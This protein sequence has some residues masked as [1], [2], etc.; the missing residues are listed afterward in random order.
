MPRSFASDVNDFNFRYP[1]FFEEGDLASHNILNHTFHPINEA[2]YEST[3]LYAKATHP[4]DFI[5][6]VEKA[7]TEAEAVIQFQANHYTL[8]ANHEKCHQPI[9]GAVSL[10]SSEAAGN[11]CHFLLISFF[12]LRKRHI[13]SLLLW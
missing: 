13:G 5:N 3:L 6:Q 10:I 8:L 7:R 4:D 1:E 2:K 9:I 12:R 11:T